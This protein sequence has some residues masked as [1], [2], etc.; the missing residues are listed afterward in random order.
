MFY[1]RK[2]ELCCASERQ[3]FRK[4]QVVLPEELANQ[5]SVLASPRVFSWKYDFL[6]ALLAKNFSCI[7]AFVFWSEQIIENQEIIDAF[8]DIGINWNK[9]VGYLAFRA[10]RD[11]VY[12][13]MEYGDEGVLFCTNGIAIRVRGASA[14]FYPWL[15]ACTLFLTPTERVNGGGTGSCMGTEAPRG[16]LWC[17]DVDE[18][19]QKGIDALSTVLSH[20]RSNCLQGVQQAARQYISAY[21]QIQCRILTQIQ[22]ETREDMLWLLFSCVYLIA[23]AA[24]C[25]MEELVQPVFEEFI[26][27]LLIPAHCA[28]SANELISF[29]VKKGVDISPETRKSAAE[30]QWQEDIQ[31]LTEMLERCAFLF[32]DRHFDAAEKYACEILQKYDYTVAARMYYT[33]LVLRGRSRAMRQ[34]LQ[35]VQELPDGSEQRQLLERECIHIEGYLP[36]GTGAF[37]SVMLT[38]ANDDAEG[39]PDAAKKNR[40]VQYDSSDV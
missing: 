1:A 21:L 18:E 40:S 13:R 32:F 31:S 9:V 38:A 10:Y 30:A 8:G 37:M 4:Y 5:R 14:E 35:S 19:N 28:E 20:L 39:W 12:N 2:I 23:L 27:S 29:L 24:S 15:E 6:K 34:W 33:T 17:F 36:K 16:I 22:T 7:P 3:H 11:D 25:N 26:N